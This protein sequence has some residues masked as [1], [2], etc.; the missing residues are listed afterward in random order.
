MAKLYVTEHLSPSISFGNLLPVPKMPP[1]ASQTVSIGGV[2]AASNAFDSSTC[3]IGVHTD[4]VCSIAFGT[5][6]TATTNSRRLAANTTE[7]F[8]VPV[9]GNFKIAVISN[10]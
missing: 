4:A 10:S 5:N 2:S 3:L 9:G 7:Y 8:E 6:P 1:V